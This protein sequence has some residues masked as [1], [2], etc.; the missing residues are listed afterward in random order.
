[1][2]IRAVVAFLPFDGPTVDIVI[3]VLFDDAHA[4]RLVAGVY[5][6]AG[7]SKSVVVLTECAREV[8][9]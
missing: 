3:S 1:M 5:P 7:A 2:V 9:N 6:E 4:L 8:R